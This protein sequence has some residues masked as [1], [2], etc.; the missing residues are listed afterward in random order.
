MVGLPCQSSI[1]WGYA[2]RRDGLLNAVCFRLSIIRERIEIG[3]SRAG[4]PAFL[5][6]RERAENFDQADVSAAP[7]A[8]QQIVG[9]WRSARNYP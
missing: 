9:P 5:D 6:T 8:S 4:F 2:A 1:V 7:G 3:S